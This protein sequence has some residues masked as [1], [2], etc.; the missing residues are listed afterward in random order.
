MI[1]DVARVT[2]KHEIAIVWLPTYA[3]YHVFAFLN[4]FLQ[5]REKLGDI[6]RMTAGISEANDSCLILEITFP[7]SSMLRCL[8]VAFCSV[9]LRV[10]TKE[11]DNIYMLVVKETRGYLEERLS[12]GPFRKI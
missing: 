6:T 5:I 9:L 11:L 2:V 4:G 10:D 12:C 8:I 7:N 1:P 3:V